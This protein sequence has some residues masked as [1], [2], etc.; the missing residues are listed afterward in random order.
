MKC[1]YC[2]EDVRDN[3]ILC[4]HCGKEW[5]A[6][7]IFMARNIELNAQLER[8]LLEVQQLRGASKDSQLWNT[9]VAV[10][11]GQ[12]ALSFSLATR[13]A[14]LA[15]S[16]QFGKRILAI[17]LI[18]AVVFVVMGFV[19]RRRGVRSQLS[20][21]AP[22]ILFAIDAV[23]AIGLSLVTAATGDTFADFFPPAILRDVSTDDELPTVLMTAAVAAAFMGLCL[24]AGQLLASA[25]M[26]GGGKAWNRL[27]AWFSV[28]QSPAGSGDRLRRVVEVLG[29]IVALL[30]SLLA[31][32]KFP[33]G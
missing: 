18:R 24:G 14:V 1:P 4:R 33:F 20:V 32:M 30:L 8:A 7:A 25:L 15:L 17:F 19:M 2:A 10:A 16:E 23:F 9:V 29:A 13:P 6:S 3:A 22:A 27:A 21:V 5:G 31:Q 28:P 11:V 12:L 26:R